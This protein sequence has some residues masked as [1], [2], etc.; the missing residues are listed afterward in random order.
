M[1]ELKNQICA[2]TLRVGSLESDYKKLQNENNTL[3]HDIEK[4]QDDCK[5][6]HSEKK[7]MCQTIKSLSTRVHFLEGNQAKDQ[8]SIR[9][10]AQGQTDLVCRS[11]RNNI[12][13]HN[14]PEDRNERPYHVPVIVRDFLI[15]DLGMPEEQVDFLSI[16]RAHRSGKRKPNAPRSIVFNLIYTEDK[17]IIMSYS[18]NLSNSRFKISSQYPPEIAEKRKALKNLMSEKYKNEPQKVL[19]Q[20]KLFVKGSEVVLPEINPKLAP[21]GYDPT[22]VDFE[23]DLPTVHES[24]EITVKG[25][26]FYGFAARISNGEDAKMVLDGIKAKQTSRPANHIT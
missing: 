5:E 13:I 14:Y 15:N 22:S 21:S 11:M 8:Q 2:L 16:D 18:R 17:D 20:D 1:E 24:E 7:S 3:R 26:A 10:L 12:M 6:L 19:K 4:L 23:T 9:K 25:N